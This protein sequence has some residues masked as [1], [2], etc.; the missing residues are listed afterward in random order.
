MPLRYVGEYI[1]QIRRTANVLDSSAT[2]GI[3]STEIVQYVDEGQS[4]LQSRISARY[5]TTFEAEVTF[6]P[7]ANQ[8]EYDFPDHTYT[9]SRIKT[10][11]Y[12]PTGQA[13]DYYPLRQTVALNR[14]NVPVNYPSHYIT[15]GFKLLVVPTINT[16]TGL[17][18]IIYEKQ[19][20]RLD[21]RR[22]KIS[23]AAISGSYYTSITL[24]NTFD[25]DETEIAAAEYL[26]AVDKHGTIIYPA[27]TVD[28]FDSSTGIITL[29]TNTAPTTTGTLAAGQYVVL[30]RYSTTHS[31]LTAPCER[32]L[33]SYGTWKTQKK[34]SNEDFEPQQEE[35]QAIEADIIETFS[36]NERDL[37]ILPYTEDFL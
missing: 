27:L 30:G 17:F 36:A 15:R 23:S 12:S 16:S 26:T 10:F 1:D 25:N 8:E 22:G 18:R 28:S 13:R 29:E 21:I 24:D 6:A 33:I 2:N 5:P 11:E 35:L 19:L 37:F 4:R 7:V 3:S 9:G 31:Q 20:P 14:I 34:D 32:Y